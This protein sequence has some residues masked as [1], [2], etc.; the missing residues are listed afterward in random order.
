MNYTDQQ[1]AL[2]AEIGHGSFSEIQRADPQGRLPPEYGEPPRD[3]MER[4]ATEY[5]DRE[6][7]RIDD[8]GLS[9][10][11]VWEKFHGIDSPEIRA[12]FDERLVLE[13]SGVRLDSLWAGG[14]TMTGDE[15]D[16]AWLAM[17]GMEA[18]EQRNP[19]PKLPPS[20][21]HPNGITTLTDDEAAARAV[22]HE[23][24][25]A[26]MH[27]EMFSRDA[28]RKHFY[29]Q[30][31]AALRGGQMHEFYEREAELRRQGARR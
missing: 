14:I 21:Q 5:A 24:A 2:L 8:P 17:F 29:G 4:L 10:I 27:H 28:L 20:R 22:E 1:T 31:Y 26:F 15:I 18:A 12:T 3:E 6:F 16:M 25:Y 11:E 13:R 19:A 30:R 7:A 9:D 23:R